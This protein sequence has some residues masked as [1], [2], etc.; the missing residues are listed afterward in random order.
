MAW[1]EDIGTYLQSQ[2]LG[3]LWTNIHYY[4]WRPDMPANCILVRPL[5]GRESEALSGSHRLE[6]KNLQIENRYQDNLKTAQ[7]NAESIRALFEYKTDLAGYVWIKDKLGNARFME[8]TDNGISRF[9]NEFEV[10]IFV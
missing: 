8:T 10:C 6:Y 3:T 7:D 2:G 1:P 9:L 5:P 4:A